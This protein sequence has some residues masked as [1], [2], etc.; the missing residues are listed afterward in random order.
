MRHALDHVFICCTEDA[1]E[2]EA[3]ARVG[4]K[5]GSSNEHRGQGT[6]CRRFFFR[7]AY[8]ELLWVSDAERARDATS[9]RTRLWE[10]WSA[11][12][13]GACPFGVVFRPRG[14]SLSEPPFATWSYH[15]PHLPH[16]I[17][18]EVGVGTLLSEPELFYWR[19]PRRPEDFRGEPIEHTMPVRD[20]TR[21]GIGIPGP[22][23]RTASAR[24]AE[25][26][27]LITFPSTTE[28][29][30]QLEF[31]GEAQRNVADLRPELP[32]VLRW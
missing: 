25:A 21:L 28:H 4:L 7:N 5:E 26:A 22:G 8:I 12:Q 27:G 19:H 18:I 13:T 23:P 29:V 24:A 11:R 31:D 2:A 30:M 9:I 32:L 10:R 6:A 1:P 3:L 20:V 17:T 16:D 15:P 14:T